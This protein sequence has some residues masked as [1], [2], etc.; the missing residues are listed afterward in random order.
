MIPRWGPADRPRI[1]AGASA[2]YVFRAVQPIR[3]AAFGIPESAAA[4][5]G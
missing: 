1:I 4:C 5:G 3:L 2:R